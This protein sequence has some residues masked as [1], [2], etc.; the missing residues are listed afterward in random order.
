MGEKVQ[1]HPTRNQPYEGSGK[2]PSSSFHGLP[3]A[4]N[5]VSIHRRGAALPPY[6]KVQNAVD[7]DVRR[8]KRPHRSP[9]YVQKS[10]GTARMSGAQ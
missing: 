3:G 5:R 6:G 8:N 10:D 9:Q 7:R 2:R 1:G 4:T